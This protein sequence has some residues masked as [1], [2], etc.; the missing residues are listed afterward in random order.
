MVVVVPVVAETEL[1]TPEGVVMFVLETGADVPARSL[2]R[3]LELLIG[4]AV[5]SR[6]IS[7]VRRA[8]LG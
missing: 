3:S 5:N 7:A 2:E 8:S 1:V 6:S 4:N